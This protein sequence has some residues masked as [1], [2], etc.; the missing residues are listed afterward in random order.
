[1][2]MKKILII[3]S[4]LMA[5][6]LA[7]CAGGNKAENQEMKAEQKSEQKS[8]RK[9]LVTYFSAT[10]TTEKVARRIASLSGA[11]IM[12]IEPVEPYTE[13]D[14]DWH[15]KQSRSSV[16]MS[17]PSARPQIKALAKEVS[18]YDVILIGFPVWWDLAPREINTFIESCDLQG[19]T[20]VPFATSGGS[21][22]VGSEAALKRTYPSLDWG[23]GCLLNDADDKT[24][25][26]W[27]E[28]I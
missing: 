19:K 13:A 8:E 9:M 20:V 14:L 22:I 25:N 7:A 26:Q 6:A 10:G 21:T 17:N 12:E 27:L 2:I 24:I 18:D 16:E 23:P 15:D 5:I 28:T 11:D 3:L 4:A 1:M